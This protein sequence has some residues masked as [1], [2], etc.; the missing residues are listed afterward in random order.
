MSQRTLRSRTLTLFL[1]LALGLGALT[2][3]CTHGARLTTPSGFATLKES[4][5][6]TYRAANAKGIVLATR[7]EPNELRANTDFWAEVLDAKFRDEGY[8]AESSRAVTTQRGL[9]GTQLMYTRT[10]GGREV[11]YWVTVFATDQRVYV[12]EAAGA[13]DAFDRARPVIDAAIGSLEPG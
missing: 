9:V 5:G 10:E 2:T 13:K 4:A 12:V 11:R 3:G 8:A 6:Y 1:G 7:S